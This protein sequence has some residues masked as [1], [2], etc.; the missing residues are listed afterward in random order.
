MEKV[1][2]DEISTQI[3]PILQVFRAAIEEQQIVDIGANL[4]YALISNQVFGVNQFI[5]SNKFTKK[6]QYKIIED[7]FFMFW[8]M[9]ER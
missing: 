9:I 5:S 2:A 6:E 1:G 7:T 3:A 4:L 8:K